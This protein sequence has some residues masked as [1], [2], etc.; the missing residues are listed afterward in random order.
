LL[1][2]GG[3]QNSQQ[4]K[5]QQIPFAIKNFI[6]E[7]ARRFLS[8]FANHFADAAGMLNG[9]HLQP[10]HAIDHRPESAADGASAPQR[11]LNV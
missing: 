6:G 5:F 4:G 9:R 7:Q 3:Q 10:C 8:F 1:D 11:D 2:L